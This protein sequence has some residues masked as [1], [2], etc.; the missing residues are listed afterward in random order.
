MKKFYAA[1]LNVE[2]AGERLVNALFVHETKEAAIKD[3]KERAHNSGKTY[4]VLEPV[5][6]FRPPAPPINVEELSFEEVVS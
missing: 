6:A 4:V 2:G 5:A 1:M 3:A